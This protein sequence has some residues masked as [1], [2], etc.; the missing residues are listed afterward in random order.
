MSLVTGHDFSTITLDK[1]QQ[2][3]ARL[4]V[5]ATSN[6]MPAVPETLQGDNRLPSGF[7]PNPWDLIGWR[8]WRWMRQSL[9]WDRPNRCRC[10]RLGVSWTYRSH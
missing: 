9:F 7:I 3:T 6:E 10:D 5:L 8:R 2:L 4:V 1:G